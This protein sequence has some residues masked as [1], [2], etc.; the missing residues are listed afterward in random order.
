MAATAGIHSNK[1]NPVS[2]EANAGSLKSVLPLDQVPTGNTRITL[3]GAKGHDVQVSPICI[4]AWSW[5]D[6]STWDWDESERPA[7]DALWDVC[8]RYGIN[9]VDTAQAYGDGESERIVGELVRRAIS[10][11]EVVIQTK[12]YVVPTPGNIIHPTSSPLR[13][14]KDSLEKMQLDFVDVYL[15]HGPIHIQSIS[16]IAKGMAECVE[17][18]LAK[19]IGVANYDRD[20]MLKMKEELAKYGIPLATNQVEYHPIRRHPELAGL[21]QACKDHGIVF[22]S[23][24]SL[25]QGR[26]TGKYHTENEPPSKRRFSSYKMSDLEPVLAVLKQIASSRGKSVSS[27]VLNYNL[28]KGVLPL[29][30]MRKPEQAE[31]NV[32]ALGWRLS[33]DEIRAIDEVSLEGKTTALWQ[34]G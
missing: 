22:Q 23:Y 12:Y 7:V 26:L 8:R 34:Q 14:L 2:E 3:S 28:S 32:Q 20:D 17:Q 9:F 15:V 18:G 5:G 29:V 16:Q 4:G 11:D 13:R 6:K 25:A 27:V 31:E 24:A 21:L 1:P 10:R 19:C 33:Y 30:G